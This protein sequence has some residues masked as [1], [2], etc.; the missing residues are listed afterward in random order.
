M[1]LFQKSTK[2]NRKKTL[3]SILC[4]KPLYDFETSLVKMYLKHSEVII[5][6]TNILNFF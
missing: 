3:E 1:P 6:H 4:N 5:Y 2:N